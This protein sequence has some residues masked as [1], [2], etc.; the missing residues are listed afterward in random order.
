MRR[1][2]LL[3][4]ITLFV[5]RLSVHADGSDTQTVM[6]VRNITRAMALVDSAVSK[7]FSGNDMKMADV[8][9]FNTSKAEGTA[10]VWPYTAALE[11]V[12]SIL[13]GLEVIKDSDPVLYAA[14]YDRYVKLLSSL[15]DNLD[16]YRGTLSLKSYAFVG[17]WIVYGVHR[18]SAKGGATVTGI[19]NVYDDQMWIMRELVRAY[20]L[21][22]NTKYLNRAERLAS[23]I[24]D[25]WDCSLDSDGN[26][27]GGITWGPGYNSKHSCSNG[28][29]ISPLVWLSQIYADKTS[30]AVYRY[31]NPDKTRSAKSMPKSEY[32]LMYAKKI[33]DWQ[34]STLYDSSHGVYYDMVGANNTIKYET[35]GGVTYRAH[36]ETGSPGG[37]AYTYNTGTMICG[38]A[39][40]YN[41]TG[42]IQYKN[43]V[44]KTANMSNAYFDR[45]KSINGE[46]Y[47]YYPY[48]QNTASGFNEWFDDVYMRA[49]VDAY[50]IAQRASQTACDNF[51][52]TLDYAYD[53]YLNDGFLPN[54]FLGGWGSNTSTKPFHQ[55]AF[56]SEYAMLVQYLAK[57]KSATYIS[58]TNKITGASAVNVYGIDGR[59]V[60][61]QVAKRQSL[62]GLEKGI[63]IVDG[64][65]FAVR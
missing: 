41:A 36:V 29:A 51:Q 45:V 15:Y 14:N 2:I 53:K 9:N 16:Y 24:I 47:Y 63:Y 8:Y 11:A 25:G 48:D 39:D 30:T 62:N 1:Y 19:E 37:T 44:V 20:K 59:I 38:G 13:E 21:T 23:Y 17:T 55:L 12:N 7:C 54:D 10:D 26:E 34:L 42:I 46:L 22:G 31:I 64:K 5:L 28:P 35:I 50:D 3:L 56:A 27:Y 4:L 43:D 58:S 57:S 33:Y 65:K 32:Y 18:G 6:Q 49:M 61:G 40:L 52:K 60:R